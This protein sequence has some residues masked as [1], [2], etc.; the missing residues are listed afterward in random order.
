M[1]IKLNLH[2]DGPDIHADIK[3][4]DGVETDLGAAALAEVLHVEDIAE[5]KAGDAGRK[6]E[7][8]WCK[9]SDKETNLS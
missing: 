9:Y 8:S 6:G 5:A 2:N 4:N 3:D 7:V 1:A